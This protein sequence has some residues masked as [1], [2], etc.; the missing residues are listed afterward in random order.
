MIRITRKIDIASL[1]RDRDQLWAEAAAA[2][3]EWHL[4]DDDERASASVAET[5]TEE[6][7]WRVVIVRHFQ[8]LFRRHELRADYTTREITGNDVLKLELKDLTKATEMRVGDVMKS[9]GFERRKLRIV[10]G[11]RRYDPTWTWLFPQGETPPEWI[12]TE[13]HAT[14]DT[15]GAFDAN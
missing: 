7:P 8:G 15:A 14:D 10:R 11:D 5:Y 2:S 13:T 12:L 6:D 9:L 1:A 4:G 3:E